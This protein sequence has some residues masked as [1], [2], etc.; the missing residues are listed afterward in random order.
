[1][2]LLDFLG[3]PLGYLWDL[4][5][6]DDWEETIR[7]KKREA[8]KKN[9][10]QALFGMVISVDRGIYRHYGIYSG[11]RKV[12]HF[13]SGK[14]DSSLCNKGMARVREESVGK[15]L[16]GQK[17]FTIHQFPSEYGK[18]INIDIPAVNTV[19]SMASPAQQYDFLR[20][21]T[22]NEKIANYHLY[23]PVETVKRARSIIGTDK[24]DLFQWNCEHFA[25]WCKT[26]IH[27]SRQAEI[28]YGWS[29]ELE[30]LD[31][32]KKYVIVD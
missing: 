30:I 24:Y 1:M 29:I 5:F 27:E 10:E 8:I 7:E 32:L 22:K 9:S 11:N 13:S 25:V 31:S 2:S 23:S 6:S 17:T 12:I 28:I 3:S 16:D 15:F 4:I 19:L 26:G 20:R 18:P 14:G 21:W